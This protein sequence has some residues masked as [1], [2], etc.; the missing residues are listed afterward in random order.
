[1][2]TVAMS[3]EFL[4]TFRVYIT[5]M[6]FYRTH[7]HYVLEAVRLISPDQNQRRITLFQRGKV[8]TTA[9]TVDLNQGGL[10]IYI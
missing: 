6:H 8:V 3:Y 1:M 10:N 7:R 4:S 2:I 9:A 5:I